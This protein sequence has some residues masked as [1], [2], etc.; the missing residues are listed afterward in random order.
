MSNWHD[1]SPE[2]V[3]VRE[4]DD[5]RPIVVMELRPP[6]ADIL[7]REW[8]ELRAAWLELPPHPNILDAID[9]AGRGLLVRF[10]AIDWQREPLELELAGERDRLAASWGIQLCQ[11]YAHIAS[12]VPQHALGAFLC[13][14]LMTDL[15]S[16]LRLAFLPPSPYHR[17]TGRFVAPEIRAGASLH[18]E[19][20]ITFLVG[21]AMQE[22]APPN[23]SALEPVIV[24]CTEEDPVRRYR[25]LREVRR[26]LRHAGRAR[27]RPR[28]E[29]HLSTWAALE[30]EMGWRIVRPPPSEVSAVPIARHAPYADTPFDRALA[31]PTPGSARAHYLDGKAFFRNGR[32]DDARAAFE[33]ALAL[34]PR[35]IE[36]M[37]LRREVDRLASATLAAAGH[38]GPPNED[39]EE[40][41]AKSARL[42]AQLAR[43]DE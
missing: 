41:L 18:D 21:R 4:Y 34:D 12:A 17:V 6:D 43:L 42:E 8:D 37:L 1:H 23:A 3:D 19:T 27:A 10:A 28:T 11:A 29:E 35:M 20:S 22:L 39:V 2:F 30:E 40:A 5:G 36:A 14:L 33:R 25:T 31:P 38:Q 24:R 7:R 15:D 32:I 26:A 13:P 16:Q 9:R